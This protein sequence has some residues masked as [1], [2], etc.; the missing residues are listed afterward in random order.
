MLRLAILN[1]DGTV[2]AAVRLD[3]EAWACALHVYG[4]SEPIRDAKGEATGRIRHLND[5]GAVLRGCLLQRSPFREADKRDAGGE[6]VAYLA[7]RKGLTR[8]AAQDVM[9]ESGLA[10]LR[11]LTDVA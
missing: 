6:L 5:A 4:G 7:D 8:E 3:A 10:G 1:D 11:A 2:A 9:A